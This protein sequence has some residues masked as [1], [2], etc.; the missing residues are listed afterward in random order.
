M[1]LKGTL[2]LL[3]LRPLKGFPNLKINLPEAGGRIPVN[4]PKIPKGLWRASRKRNS[5][6][7]GV[8][9]PPSVASRHNV[10]R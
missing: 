7:V 5:S 2:R 1:A 4:N 6:P 3:D 10:P 8:E 9:F